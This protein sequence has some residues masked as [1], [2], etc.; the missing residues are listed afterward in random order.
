MMLIRPLRTNFSEILIR[1]QTFQLK[2]MH[3]KML[4]VKWHPLC[5]GLNVLM[6]DCRRATQRDDAIH[7]HVQ[8]LMVIN[9]LAPGRF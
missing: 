5:L 4:S 6:A 9:S 7:P 2:K 8:W 3:L 1:I